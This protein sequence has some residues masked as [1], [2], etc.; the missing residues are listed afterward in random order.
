M[1]I[2]DISG[3]W[4]ERRKDEKRYFRSI[5]KRPM[6]WRRG[7]HSNNEDNNEGNN[8]D[9]NE[10]DNEDNNE[11]REPSVSWKNTEPSSVSLSNI[12]YL[13]CIKSVGWLREFCRVTY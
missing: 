12:M 3:L 8:E 9:N 13:R 2:F 10:D 7:S 6:K 4:M 1:S 5:A 11:G